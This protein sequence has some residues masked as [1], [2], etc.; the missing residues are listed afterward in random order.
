MLQSLLGVWTNPSNVPL[1]CPPPPP[2]DPID[3]GGFVDPASIA[4]AYGWMRVGFGVAVLVLVL[5]CYLWTSRSLSV[6][7]VRRWYAF[8]ALAGVAGAA[9]PFAV[10]QLVPLRALAGSC[11]TNPLSFRWW[12]PLARI[13]PLSLWWLVWA[14][15]AFPLVSLLFTQLAGR[16]PASGGFFHHQGCPAPRWNPFGA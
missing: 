13:Y 6:S 7:F 9:I 16:H 3:P 4:A 2:G 8:W 14:L 5:A 10:L 1:V 12:M 15:V 11:D